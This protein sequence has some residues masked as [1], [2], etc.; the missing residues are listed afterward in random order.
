M[1]ENKPRIPKEVTIMA[2]NEKPQ[3]TPPAMH[4]K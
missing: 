4:L 3:K 1:K 2:I